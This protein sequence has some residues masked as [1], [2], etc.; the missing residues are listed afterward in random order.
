MA[1][2]AIYFTTPGAANIQVSTANASVVTATTV[3]SLLVGTAAGRRISRVRV[4]HCLDTAPSANKVSFWISTDNGVTKRFL[5]DVLL[6][7]PGAPSATVRAAYAEVPELVGKV[8]FGTTNILYA[9][10]WIAQAANVDIEYND[11]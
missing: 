2:A 5:C 3:V 11:A 7:V 10:S 1:T 4:A 6:G 9:S 8:L